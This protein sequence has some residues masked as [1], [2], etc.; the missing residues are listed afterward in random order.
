MDSRYYIINHLLTSGL[1][2]EIVL[3]NFRATIDFFLHFAPNES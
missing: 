1:F 2:G 3:S